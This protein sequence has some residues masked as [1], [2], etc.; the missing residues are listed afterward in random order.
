[1][2]L[3]E[4]FSGTDVAFTVAKINHELPED[5]SSAML[6]LLSNSTKVHN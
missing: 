5:T 6:A 3:E 4:S 2:S 1:M